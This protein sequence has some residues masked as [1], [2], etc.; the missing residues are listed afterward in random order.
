MFSIKTWVV[1]I[2]NPLYDTISYNK[3]LDTAGFK[4]MDPQSFTPKQKCIHIIYTD[5]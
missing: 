1:S 3:G 4:K 2:Q 5:Q